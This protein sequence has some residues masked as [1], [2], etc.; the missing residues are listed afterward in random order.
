MNIWMVRRQLFFIQQRWFSALSFLLLDNR[1]SS[2]LRVAL[3]RMNGAK[4]GKGCFIRGSLQFQEGFNVNIGDD[5]FINAGCCFDT[6]ASI[7]IGN[8]VSMGYNVTLVTGDHHLGPPE[9]RS[10]DFNP[11]PIVIEDGVWVGA[12]AT[13]LAG[14][15]IGRGSVIMANSVVGQDIPPNVMVGGFPARAIKKLE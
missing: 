5:V 12:C 7:T 6:S 1:S 13:I 3:L 10:G 15:T 11:R 2:N 9:R 8:S 4:I 14:V